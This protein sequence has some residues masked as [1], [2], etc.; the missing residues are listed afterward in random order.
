LTT[1]SQLSQLPILLFLNEFKQLVQDKKFYPVPRSV[2]QQA[3]L[4]LGLNRQT[5]KDEILSLTVEDYCSGPN[6]DKDL[7]GQ[8][9]VF[10]KV[11]GGQEVYIKLKIA[12]HR[13]G[14]IAKCISFHPAEHKLCFPYINPK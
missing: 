12:E 7:P 14:K 8:I 9:W 11:I 2:N 3:L 1:L 6:P 13:S 10:G 4:N 5:Q